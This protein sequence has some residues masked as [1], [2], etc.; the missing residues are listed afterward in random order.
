MINPVALAVFLHVPIQT[1]KK[2]DGFRLR[3]QSTYRPISGFVPHKG[4]INVWIYAEVILSH[5]CVYCITI[6]IYITEIETF[7]KLKYSN[8][9]CTRM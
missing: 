5:M 7:Y 8:N 2:R 6:N 1:T 3:I 4:R 9:V